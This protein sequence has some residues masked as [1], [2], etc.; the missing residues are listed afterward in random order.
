MISVKRLGSRGDTIVE[1]LL[2]IAVATAVLGGAYASSKNSLAG[3]RRS[4]ERGEALKLLG[5]QL[6]RLKEGAKD[7]SGINIFTGTNPFCIVTVATPTVRQDLV[8]STNPACRQG[9]GGRYAL[10]L[11]RTAPNTFMATAVWDR[12]GGG[13]SDQIQMVYRV[14]DE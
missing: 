9:V 8:A 14:Y 6:E 12:V 3:T 13:G 5:G 4:Q 2:A 10:S 7:T 11:N 1:V